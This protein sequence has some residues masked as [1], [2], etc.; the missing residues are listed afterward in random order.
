MHE[1]QQVMH[2]G[3][4]LRTGS[5]NRGVRVRAAHAVENV[6]SNRRRCDRERAQQW[7]REG[8]GFG[9]AQLGAGDWRPRE[10]SGHRYFPQT[11]RCRGMA[12]SP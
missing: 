6:R 8:D 2:A 5:G 1:R 4:V 12:T 3:F 7:G 10:V 11:E 9:R